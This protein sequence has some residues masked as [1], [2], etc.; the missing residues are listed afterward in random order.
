MGQPGRRVSLGQPGDGVVA[1]DERTSDGWD[2]LAGLERVEVYQATGMIIEM[3]GLGPLD[4]LVRLRAYA[5]AHAMTAS[6]TAWA[7][8][9]RSVVLTDDR[10]PRPGPSR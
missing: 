8:L 7:I 9:G 4:A 6:E 10:A 5:Y 1:E 2:Q 3:L